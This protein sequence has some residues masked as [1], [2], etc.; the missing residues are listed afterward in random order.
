MKND[1]IIEK[2]FSIKNQIFGDRVYKVITIFGLKIKKRNKIRELA[3]QINI[4]QNSVLPII[5][6]HNLKTNY[7]INKEKISSK[8]KFFNNYGI[9]TEKRSTKLI[10]S[11]TSYPE[12][13]YD[14]HYCLYSL[15][16][17]ELKPD[18]V[19]LWLAKEQFP[20]L[21]KDI[22]HKVLK[23]KE[24]GLSIKWCNDIKSY[25]KLIP[26][27]KVFPNDI[28]VTADDDLYYKK[29]WLKKLYEEY[30]KSDKNCV[31]AHRCHRIN[32]K[33][34]E[35][36]PYN[37]WQKCIKNNSSSFLNFPTSGGGILYSPKSLYED[38]LNQDLFREHTPYADDIW[39]WAMSILNN[40]KIRIVERP[41][42]IIYINPERELN[43]NNDGTLFQTN[44]TGNDIQLQNIINYYPQI[45]DILNKNNIKVS[46]IIP[47]YNVEKYLRQC[48]NSITNQ[49]LEDIEIICIND[50]STDNSLKILKKYAQKDQRIIIINK[51]NSGAADSRNKGL[52]IAQ[53]EYIGF[54]D[55][56]DWIDKN[57]YEKLYNVALKNGADIARCTYKYC[58]KN[59]IKD[60]E[61]NRIIENRIQNNEPIFIQKQN[62]SQKKKN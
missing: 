15:L 1:K 20:N 19:I 39:F 7:S 44:K 21:E 14:I 13:M 33:N 42:D 17:Q 48:L 59:T 24:N 29:D 18:E 30:L 25:K 31:I 41:N 57:Y 47:V 3:N 40:K 16:T 56:D 45:T 43:I 51:E 11:L 46:V 53:G 28:I 4:L 60:S 12:R 52:K 26:A 9:T 35:I 38:I 27:L 2:I 6:L 55:G 8:I 10:V 37:T 50:G 62:F 22:P 32:I 5:K 36:L 58:Y 34:Q 23:L 54:V 49:T 61:L